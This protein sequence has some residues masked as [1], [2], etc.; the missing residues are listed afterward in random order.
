MPRVRILEA[1]IV[2]KDFFLMAVLHMKKSERLLRSF[3]GIERECRF[4]PR[5][6][7]PVRVLRVLFL[8]VGAVAK[9]VLC[10]V[11]RG[12]STPDLAAESALDELRKI[13]GVIQ[14]RMRQ[15]DIRDV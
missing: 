7:M 2:G 11:Q 1:D 4:V 15:D 13:A 5:I 6:S 12:R 3:R 10:Y 8:N 9:D 14:M